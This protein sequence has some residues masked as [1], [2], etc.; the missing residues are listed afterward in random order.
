MNAKIEEVVKLCA[1]ADKVH[2]TEIEAIVHVA[3]L[4]LGHR[5]PVLVVAEVAKSKSIVRS[6]MYMN[7]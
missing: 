1:D 3:E 7:K 5:E 2:R 4:I 6:T